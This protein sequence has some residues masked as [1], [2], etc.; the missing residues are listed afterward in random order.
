MDF[1]QNNNQFGV[2]NG[3]SPQNNMGNPQT[4]NGGQ[5]NNNYYTP[6]NQNFNNQY[7][8]Y[9]PQGQPYFQG[10]FQNYQQAT[11]VNQEKFLKLR[12]QKDEIRRFSKIFALAML[13]NS[14]FQADGK[15]I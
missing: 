14:C 3:T 4:Y 13:I 2:N 9:N 10:N 6:P 11:F 5:Y 12:A 15:P 7:N 8:S 1:N